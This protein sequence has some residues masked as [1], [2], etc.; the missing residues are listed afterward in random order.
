MDIDREVCCLVH[1]LGIVGVGRWGSIIAQRIREAGVAEISVI[2]DL[3]PSRASSLASLTGARVAK[4]LGDFDRSRDLVGVIIATSIESLASAA[5]VLIDSL[6]KAR[7]LRELAERRGV[8]A[9]PG[10][11]VRFDPVSMWVKNY[12]EKEK[13]SL[14][15]LYLYRLS[16]RPPHARS[17]SILLDLS[18]HDIDLARFFIGGD[19]T[20]ISWY[21]HNLEVDEGLTLYARHDNGVVYIH[22]DGF[23][24]YKVRKAIAMFDKSYVEAD[25]IYRY[26]I[27]KKEG[28]KDYIYRSVG[29]VEALINE[30]TAFINKCLGK[31]VDIPTLRDA[32]KAHEVI[33]AIISKTVVSD[34]THKRL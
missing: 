5:Q 23:S 31:E 10:F 7:L 34:V 15:D 3:D 32:E 4:D 13:E 25:Y 14:G 19:I 24:R 30:I 29:G 21:I 27:H 22:T 17:S 28:E 33:A 26:I 1:K 9:M 16:R 12:I 11:I 18:I 2:Y 20:P 8:I 6:E